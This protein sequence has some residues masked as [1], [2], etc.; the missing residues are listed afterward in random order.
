MSRSRTNG[1]QE[2][3]WGRLAFV[4]FT[5]AA[6]AALT[7]GYTLQR[8]A[9]DVLGQEIKAMEK[10]EAWAKGEAVL[11]RVRLARLRRRDVIVRLVQEMNLNLT[12]IVP[13]QRRIIPLL[14]SWDQPLGNT[15]LPA[16]SRSVPAQRE[17]NLR[18]LTG[19]AALPAPNAR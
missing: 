1:L 14:P 5:V 3:R 6:I 4:G 15:N 18:P 11:W 16:S 10:K 2:M 12:N 9:H 8:G 13:N 7:V 17:V 19:A